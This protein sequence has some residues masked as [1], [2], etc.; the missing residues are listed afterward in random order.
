MYTLQDSVNEREAAD[1]AMFARQDKAEA[2]RKEVAAILQ[3]NPQ[4][5][6]MMKNGKQAYYV[7]GN[8][9][10]SFNINDLV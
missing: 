6:V 8:Y 7:T 9:K 10:T 4:I 5:G 1:I 3:A 2:A